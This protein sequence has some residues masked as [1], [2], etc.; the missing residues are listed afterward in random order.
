[1]IIGAITGG[2][3]AIV[4]GINTSL[5]RLR[6]AKS[7][8]EKRSVIL[9]A[10]CYQVAT[11]ALVALIVLSGGKYWFVPWIITAILIPFAFWQRRKKHSTITGQETEEAT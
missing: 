9:W 10:I 4:S 7:P 6:S 11:I 1:M 8:K 2:I 5:E 3:I